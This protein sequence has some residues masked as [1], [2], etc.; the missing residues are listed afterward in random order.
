M[1]GCGFSISVESLGRGMV[2]GSGSKLQGAD[3]GFPARH[4]SVRIAQ[5]I[6]ECSYMSPHLE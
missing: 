2:K 4:P 1:R 5:W 3:G 6:R